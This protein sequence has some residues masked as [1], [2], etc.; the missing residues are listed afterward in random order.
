MIKGKKIEAKNVPVR[1]ILSDGRK[2]EKSLRDFS[3]IK[4]PG[5]KK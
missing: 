5:R 4:V 3:D 1:N 2:E